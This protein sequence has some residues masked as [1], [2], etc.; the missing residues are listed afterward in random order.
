MVWENVGFGK[1]KDL[2][3][4][5]FERSSELDTHVFSRKLSRAFFVSEFAGIVAV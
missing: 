5:P 4:R 3:F 2:G 1:R